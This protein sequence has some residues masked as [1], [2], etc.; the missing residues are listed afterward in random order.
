LR[1]EGILLLEARGI[2]EAEVLKE[3]KDGRNERLMLEIQLRSRDCLELGV[4][5]ITYADIDVAM[6]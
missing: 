3:K 5:K 1:W 6:P 2:R 4:N